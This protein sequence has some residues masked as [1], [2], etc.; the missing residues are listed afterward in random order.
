MSRMYAYIVHCTHRRWIGKPDP[1]G[2]GKFTFATDDL[3]AWRARC[4]L[5]GVRIDK[6]ESTTGGAT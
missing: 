3:G 4:A 1:S 2:F 5:T 6:V